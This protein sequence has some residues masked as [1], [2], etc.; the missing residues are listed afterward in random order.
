M[1]LWS[2][3]LRWRVPSFLNIVL[4]LL[5]ILQASCLEDL[6][7]VS[8][9]L[10]MNIFFISQFIRFYYS[11]HHRTMNGEISINLILIYI[12]TQR[13]MEKNIKIKKNQFL[14]YRLDDLQSMSVTLFMWNYF[15]NVDFFLFLLTYTDEP[16]ES[17]TTNKIVML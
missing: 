4:I 10:V 1:R 7:C 2:Y 12:T 3:F 14:S 13:E 5:Y 17:K 9:C 6:S 16:G 11:D 15:F 8:L